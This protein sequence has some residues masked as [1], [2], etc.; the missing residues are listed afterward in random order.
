MLLKMIS[1]LL[2]KMMSLIGRRKPKHEA[3]LLAQQQQSP[4]RSMTPRSSPT[5]DDLRSAINEIESLHGVR[6]EKVIMDAGDYLGLAKMCR[7]GLD[8]FRA[9]SH[10]IHGSMAMLWGIEIVVSRDAAPGI[11]R[12]RA[13]WEMEFVF[14]VDDRPFLGAPSRMRLLQTAT[15]NRQG[16]KE[17]TADCCGKCAPMVMSRYARGG[18]LE[19]SAGIGSTCACE[20][21]TCGCCVQPVNEVKK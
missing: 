12:I 3:P 11:F 17:T 20:R 8:D 15:S 21:R 19:Y 5:L 4:R 10:E 9:L 2:A 1:G 16:R 14:G 6:V 18:R 13:G 7:H